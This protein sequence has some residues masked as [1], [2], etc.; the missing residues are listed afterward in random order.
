MHVSPHV[1]VRLQ[2]SQTVPQVVFAAHVR[3]LHPEALKLQLDDPPGALHRY[4]LSS[5]P[6]TASPQLAVTAPLKPVPEQVQ[7]EPAHSDCQTLPALS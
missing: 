7:V 3:Q 5:A 4:V 2:P 1:S 6:H